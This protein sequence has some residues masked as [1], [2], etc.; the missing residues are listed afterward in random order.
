MGIGKET[1]WREVKTKGLNLGALADNLMIKTRGG[2]IMQ[3]FRLRNLLLAVIIG[4]IFSMPAAELQAA[5][6]GS[7]AYTKDAIGLRAEPKLTASV[8]ATLAAGVL[9][10]VNYCSEGWCNVST[11]G[12][13]GFVFEKFLTRKTPP[14]RTD[15]DRGQ[16]N[17]Q[18]Q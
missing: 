17:P 13:T 11:K 6:P 9:V 3:N 7:T 14:P 18:G 4:F 10:T 2:G 5:R 16:K 15:Q 8:I 12:L 1:I